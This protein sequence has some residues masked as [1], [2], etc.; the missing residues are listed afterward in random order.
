MTDLK[1]CLAYSYTIHPWCLVPRHLRLNTP[2]DLL[3]THVA[4]TAKQSCKRAENM[5]AVTSLFLFD[6]EKWLHH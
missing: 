2:T 4:I 6:S 3:N 5:A 1:T